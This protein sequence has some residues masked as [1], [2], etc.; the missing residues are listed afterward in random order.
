[1]GNT[2][3]SP[4]PVHYMPGAS[5][6]VTAQIVS[7]HGP[8]FPGR[9]TKIALCVELLVWTHSLKLKTGQVWVLKTLCVFFVQPYIGEGQGL[10]SI[11]G[12]FHVAFDRLPDLV[13]TASIHCMGEAA[14]RWEGGR[15]D[16][17]F[18]G[19]VSPPWGLW[20]GLPSS[21]C[22]AVWGQVLR[23]IMTWGLIL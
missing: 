9:G 21:H 16:P 7:R 20:G 5:L 1:M 13:P 22:W 10:D 3:A 4:A 14:L 8:L 6:N 11:H 23:W 2:S 15:Q 17:W 19:L 18:Q 12:D